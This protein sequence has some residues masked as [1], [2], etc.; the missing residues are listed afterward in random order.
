[1]LPIVIVAALGLALVV[2]WWAVPLAAA[3]WG[4]LIAGSVDASGYMG[5]LALAAVNAAVGAVIGI[6][7]T[8]TLRS[9]RVPSS[10]H[11]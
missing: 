9:R 1:V 5:A 10:S 8:R 7:I 3:G 6:G 4:V 2:R 11:A